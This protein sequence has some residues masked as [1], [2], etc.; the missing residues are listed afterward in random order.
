MEK[1]PE[2]TYVQLAP[3]VRRET[4]QFE[5]GTPRTAS[6]N[7]CIIY[8]SPVEKKHTSPSVKSVT[9]RFRA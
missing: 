4:S 1:L 7:Q 2:A 5:S 3:V 8:R 6:E 9:G